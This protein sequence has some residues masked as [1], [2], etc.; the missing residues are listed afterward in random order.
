M[1]QGPCLFEC[2]QMN[3]RRVAFVLLEP[4][5]RVLGG[6]FDH[7]AVACDLRDHTRCGDGVADAVALDDG[8]LMHGKIW[9]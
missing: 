3:W 7:Q 6:E 1:G 9:H 5:V 2:C 8:A 4:I